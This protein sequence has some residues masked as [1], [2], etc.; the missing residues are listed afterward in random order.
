MRYTSIFMY[1]SSV[2]RYIY[3]VLVQ[4]LV[5]Y[6]SSEVRIVVGELTVSGGWCFVSFAGTWIWHVCRIVTK[7]EPNR[8]R[9]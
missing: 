5:V 3:R 1:S 8:S 6:L 4:V 7:G 9:Q 2:Y